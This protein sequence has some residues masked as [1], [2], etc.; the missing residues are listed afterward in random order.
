[1]ATAL[2]AASATWTIAAQAEET[3]MWWDF[4]GGGDG[5]RMKQMIGD[6]NAAHAGKIKIDATTL[7]WGSPILRQGADLGRGG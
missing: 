2:V 1:M 5:V 7:E 6:F 3:V 4:L